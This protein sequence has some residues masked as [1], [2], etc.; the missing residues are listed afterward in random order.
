V[1]VGG[2]GAAT[3]KVAEHVTSASQLLVTLNVTVFEPPQAKGAPV[4]SFDNDPLHP[5]VKPA[6]PS[7]VANLVLISTWVWQETS[8]TGVGQVSTTAGAA[9]MVKVAVC[10]DVL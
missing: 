7:H 4:L 5:P 8:L 1:I 10:V 3:L 6:V 2:A 9:V